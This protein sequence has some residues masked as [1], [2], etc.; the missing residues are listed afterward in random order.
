MNTTIIVIIL[1]IFAVAVILLIMAGLTVHAL[2]VENKALRKTKSTMSNSLRLKGIE[3]DRLL[4]KI[5]RLE[6]ET[7]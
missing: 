4:K 1:A 2:E 7:K 3:V 6:K 5:N